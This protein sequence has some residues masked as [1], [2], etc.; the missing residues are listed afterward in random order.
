MYSTDNLYGLVLAGGKSSRMGQDKGDLRYY[1]T[2][3]RSYLYYSLREFC[4]QT[5]ISCREDQA[6]ILQS[7]MEYILD[8]D[9]YK[10]PL[11]GILSAHH[12]YPDKA[13]LVVAV[14]LPHVHEETIKN[15]LKHRN[16]SKMATVYATKS[17][18][19]P[20]PLIGIWEPHGL[21][22]AEDFIRKT[23]KSCP[24]KFLMNQD[25]QL[26]FPEND[27]ELFNANYPEDYKLAKSIINGN[28]IK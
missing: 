23:E 4:P 8:E 13:W 28:E 22:A 18:G 24:R 6:N 16:P 5:F 10:G 21:E 14:D 15:L 3:H 7:G 2:N 1:Q 19:L 17:S 11:N 9:T 20:E 25:V 12:A 26:V 27:L